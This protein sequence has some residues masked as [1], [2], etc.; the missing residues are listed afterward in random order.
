MTATVLIHGGGLDRR[1]WDRLIPL[2]AEPVL[3]VDLPGRGD[4]PADLRTV[5]FEDCARSVEADL[6]AAGLG[7][8]ILVGHSLAGCSMP[9]TVG[10]LG[11]RVSGL[12]FV[13]CTVPEPGLSAI[14]TLDPEVQELIRHSPE[15]DE[16]QIMDP[17]MARVVLGDDLDDEQF[18]WC[19]ERL[20]PEAPHLSWDPVDLSPFQR[21][22]PRTWVRTRH[23]AIVPAD[24][25]LRFAANV[26][27]CPVVDI[28]A[29]HM[30]MVSQPAQ[31][32]RILESLP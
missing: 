21:T 9:A 10:R 18:Q 27:D 31:L 2:L 15:R 7:E 20:V 22:V 14:D 19:A 1:C 13:A 29:G 23:D 17:T 11:D 4:H 12:V 24:K 16:P 32:A 28:D 8:V 26:G 6:D 5:T 3:A 30:C 25:Q